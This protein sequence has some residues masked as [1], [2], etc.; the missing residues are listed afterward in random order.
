MGSSI[1]TSPGAFLQST[2]SWAAK[3]S[4]AWR[5]F[6]PRLGRSWASLGSRLELVIPSNGNRK[7]RTVD[8]G[9]GPG[10]RGPPRSAFGGWRAFMNS[11]NCDSH[12]LCRPLRCS[13]VTS[14]GTLL[15][16]KSRTL[17]AWMR[18]G[19]S[20][21]PFPGSGPAGLCSPVFILFPCSAWERPGAEASVCSAAI[22]LRRA[23]ETRADSQSWQ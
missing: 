19:A 16:Q 23:N 14:S 5:S 9:R 18:G 22:S 15:S 7:P 3:L 4:L 2:L 12:C 6:V 21:P 1:G 17:L 20:P 10:F 11:C 13:R 8:L